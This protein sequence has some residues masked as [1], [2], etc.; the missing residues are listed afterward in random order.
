MT[1]VVRSRARFN[2]YRNRQIVMEKF[3]KKFKQEL[4]G[5]QG[6]DQHVI[7]FGA[8]SW[9]TRSISVPRKRLVKALA[10]HFLVV[11]VPEAW[12]SSKCFSC[13]SNL[14]KGANRVYRCQTAVG[15]DSCILHQHQGEFAMD[16][17][18]WGACGILKKGLSD[19]PTPPVE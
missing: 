12:T 5:R 7:F 11:M 10:E 4:K 13:R 2:R 16:R 1:H 9:K 8:A 3:V 19:R 18:D 15:V 14:V 6:M 17:D